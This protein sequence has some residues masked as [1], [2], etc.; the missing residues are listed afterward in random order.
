MLWNSVL[1]LGFGM[2]LDP[3]RLGLVAVVLSRKRPMLNL[4]AF[5]MGGMIAGIGI[6]MAVLVV[7]RDT[8]MAA[9]RSAAAVV[10]DVRSSI[11][12]FEGGHLKITLGAIALVSLVVLL[13]RERARMLRPVAA[14]C[15]HSDGSGGAAQPRFLRLFAKLGTLN[16]NILN[17]GF[18]WPAFVVGLGSATPPVETLILLTIIM[19]S[20]AAIGTQFSA[21]LVYTV[22][23]LAVIEIP[24]VCYLVEPDKTQAVMLRVQNWLHVHRARISQ[25]ALGVSGVALMFQGIGSL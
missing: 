23:V 5:W 7:M 24:L 8:A 6:G 12:F 17:R 18:F 3:L 19:A 21:F 10:A 20:G 2:A 4:F 15:G 25:T 14:V 22:M 9:L 16:Q 1:F 11:A 13:A